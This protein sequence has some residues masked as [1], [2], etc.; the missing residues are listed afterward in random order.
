MLLKTEKRSVV[1]PKP[2]KKEHK[3]QRQVLTER[4]LNPV[5]PAPP[6]SK[7]NIKTGMLFNN[8]TAGR[9]RKALKGNHRFMI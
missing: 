1:H 5:K 2:F 4:N 6:P 7:G 8:G 3:L 9:N